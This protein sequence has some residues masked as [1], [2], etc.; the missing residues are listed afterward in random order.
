MK[1]ENIDG[2]NVRVRRLK[3][4][5]LEIEDRDV[6]ISSE[7]IKLDSA[8]KFC[9]VASTGGHAKI[10]VA[11][12]RIK[13]NGEVCLQRGKKLYPGDKLKYRNLV[14]TMCIKG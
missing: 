12:G 6:F 3:A 1:I 8:L 5:P 9:D 4:V 13:V 10:L 14:F 2:K 7:F 11:E